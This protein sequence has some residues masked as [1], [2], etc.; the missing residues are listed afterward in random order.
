M[1][2]TI[3]KTQIT[4]TP[5][6]NAPTA[7]IPQ[8]REFHRL[9]AQGVAVPDAGRLVSVDPLLATLWAALPAS[10]FEALRPGGVPPLAPVAPPLA[11]SLAPAVQPEARHGLSRA[12][13]VH[14]PTSIDRHSDVVTKALSREVTPLLLA[15]A[16]LA[17]KRGWYVGASWYFTV[18]SLVAARIHAAAAAGGVE[19]SLVAGHLLAARLAVLIPPVSVFAPPAVDEPPRPAPVFRPG[20]RR[21]IAARRVVPKAANAESEAEVPTG[22]ELT[23]RRHELG[24]SQRDLA[25]AMGKS[26]GLLAEIERGKRAHPATRLLMAETLDRLA[27]KPLPERP[28]VRTRTSEFTDE[29][30]RQIR[31][32]WQQG[33]GV[34]I[35]ALA[36]RYGRAVTTLWMVCKGLSY[37][38][39]SD[40][41][42]PTS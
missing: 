21:L 33:K 16:V 28:A 24:L 19:A 15:E 2:T 32:D 14:V 11:P 36:E 9:V 40:T 22:E 35:A 41:E 17:A 23:R 6:E 37:Q 30:V 3:E 20:L 4:L 12:L 38:H 13:L 29:Q 5:A 25:D 10:H 7:T 31:R 39:V 27:A 1:T 8:F 26:R 42:P 18:P 34:T